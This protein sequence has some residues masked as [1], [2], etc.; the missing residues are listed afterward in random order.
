SGNDSVTGNAAANAIHGGG[1][2]DT[3][4]GLDGA[5]FL[6]GGT[7]NDWLIGDTGADSFYATFGSG[8]DTVADFVHSDG[9]KIDFTS[10]NYVHNLYQV[11]S[12][13]MQVGA[14]TFID[15]GGGDT[16]TLANFTRTNLVAGDFKFQSVTI[17]E[18]V[19]ATAVAQVGNGYFLDSSNGALGPQLRQGGSAFTVGSNGNWRMIGAEQQPNG[20]AMWW[21]NGV[22][23]QYMM[24]NSDLG[25]NVVSGGPVVNA[26]SYRLQS[27]EG[28]FG[29]D[30]NS[31]GTIGTVSTVIE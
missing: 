22:A 11:Y 26:I 13:S 18:S 9:D 3:L 23:D 2:A 28:S 15:L 1:G 19:G 27:L 8:Q 4:N 6:D 14:N 30:L 29:Q 5:D 20:Y 31:D 17:T 7:G 24:W 25:G 21:R 16:L 12:R 10:F